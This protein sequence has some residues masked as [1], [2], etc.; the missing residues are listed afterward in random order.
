MIKLRFREA[1][2]P[3]ARIIREGLP[4]SGKLAS[5]GITTRETLDRLAARKPK[6]PASEHHIDNAD[7]RAEATENAREGHRALIEKLRTE[8]RERSAKGRKDFGMAHDHQRPERE[9]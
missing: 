8:F 1:G 9:R 3:G 6:E 2:D 4:N 7:L 5:L